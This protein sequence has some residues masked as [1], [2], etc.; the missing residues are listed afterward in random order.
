MTPLQINTAARQ[1]YNAVGDSFWSDAEIYDLIYQACT[2]L[3]T[4][5]YLIERYYTA[6][7]VADTQQYSYPTNAFAIKRITYD[8]VRLT[9]IDFR[10]DDM[11]TL[12]N[13]ATTA[14]GTPQYWAEFNQVF[15]LRPI[16]SAVGTL[17][18]YA[19]A[20]PQTIISTSTL[21]IPDEWHMDLVYFINR[22]MSAKNKN[23]EGAQ[24]YGTLWE[25]TVERAVQFGQRKK[26]G[27][28]FAIVQDV[29]ILPETIVGSI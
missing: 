20:Q 9:R 8:G 6:S 16:P 7:T 13:Q 14:T 5:A 15:Y 26:R 4:K 2:E 21:E 17:G 18:V 3:A 10:Q 1:R 11:L 19:Y 29:D 25:K 28:S 23:Y 22:E 27:D 12:W 24:Y